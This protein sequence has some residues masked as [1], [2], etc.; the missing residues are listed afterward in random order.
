MPYDL[1]YSHFSLSLQKDVATGQTVDREGVCLRS[2]LEAG[3]EKVQKADAAAA[4]YAIAGFAISDN[5][6]IGIIPVVEEFTIP[7]APG[8][9]TVQLAH[10]SLVG[11]APNSSVRVY[12][13]TGSADMTEV[14]GAPA[15]TQF[16]PAVTTGVLTFN[17]AQ[18]GNSIRV[19]Y[20]ANLTVAEARL[21]YF[22]RNINN[23]A[24]AI[25]NTVVVGGGTGEI[26]TAEYDTNVDWSTAI[27]G[28]ANPIK[29]GADGILTI[30][31]AG[32]DI[33]G[34]KVIHVPDVDQPYLG[35]AFNLPG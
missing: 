13:V 26:Y 35:L 8:P 9:Y 12:N 5:E 29:T 33:P 20:R 22:Q 18:A 31:G 2:V 34:G 3:E 23:D 17:V 16:Q 10:A 21:R 30:G 19:W 4:T 14:A 25:F 24:G 6:T 11:T 28:G 1:K 32:T 27:P 15:A 7:A